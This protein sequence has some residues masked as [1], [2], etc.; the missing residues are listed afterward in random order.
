MSELIEYE[1]TGT[2]VVLQILLR[3]EKKIDQETTY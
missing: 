1:I 3:D 2:R